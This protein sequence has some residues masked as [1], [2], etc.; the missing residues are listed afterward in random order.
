MQGVQ[1]KLRKEHGDEKVFDLTKPFI[2][3]KEQQTEHE[4][5]EFRRTHVFQI[6]YYK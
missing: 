3:I 2:E 1:R 4:L 5:E 6:I